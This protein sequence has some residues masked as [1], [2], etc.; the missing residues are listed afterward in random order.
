MLL[1]RII[2]PA[3]TANT[4]S[5]QRIIDAI[6]GSVSACATICKVYATPHESTPA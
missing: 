4:D 3:I 5:R 2:I 1:P 6:V